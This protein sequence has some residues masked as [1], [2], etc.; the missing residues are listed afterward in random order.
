VK[1]RNHLADV[2]TVSNVQIIKNGVVDIPMLQILS[3]EGSVIDGAV[4]PTLTK[5]ESL[6]IYD[7]ME[8]IR[9]LDERM[10]GAQRQ[11]R[12]SFYLASTGEEAASVAI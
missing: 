11:G 6:K 2:K 10:V 5:E 4:E 12:I 9:V 3:A 7:T 1:D 8:Y